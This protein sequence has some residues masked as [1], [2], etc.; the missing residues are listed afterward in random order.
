VRTLWAETALAI[1]LELFVA[2][3]LPPGCSEAGFRRGEG[4]LVGD[5]VVCCDHQQK[6][7]QVRN[8]ATERKNVTHFGRSAILGLES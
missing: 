7:S 6:Q 2:R 8:R 4:A 1:K 5:T 3:I